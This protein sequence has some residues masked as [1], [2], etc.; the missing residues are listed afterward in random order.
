MN[1]PFL[2][3]LVNLISSG[4]GYIGSGIK[5]G[6]LISGLTVILSFQFFVKRIKLTQLVLFIP[7]SVVLLALLIGSTSFRGQLGLDGFVQLNIQKML[8]FIEYFLVSPESNHI[9]DFRF[10]IRIL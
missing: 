6:I 9:I 3:S 1:N 2:I 7:I 4:I 8:K 5:A 10:R